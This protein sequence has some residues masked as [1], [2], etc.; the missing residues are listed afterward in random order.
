MEDLVATDVI[1]TFV[2]YHVKEMTS[3]KVNDQLSDTS[4]DRT[5]FL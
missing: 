1:Q 4:Y 3:T 2:K 5:R